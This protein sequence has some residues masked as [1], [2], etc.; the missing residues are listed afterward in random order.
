MRIKYFNRYELKYIIQ[1]SQ[2]DEMATALRDYMTF[3]PHSDDGKAYV[4]TSLY[5]DTADYRAYWNKIEGHRYRRKVRIRVYDAT[6]VTPETDCFVEIKARHN[7]VLQKKRVVLPYQDALALCQQAQAVEAEA[8][9]EATIQEVRYLSYALDLRPTAVVSYNRLAFNGSE[10]DVGLRVTFDTNLQ[11]RT[12][13][14]SLLTSS[15]AESQY[16]VPPNYCIMEIKVNNRVPYWLTEF[17]GKYRCTLQRISKYCAALEN[18]KALL[19]T[20]RVVAR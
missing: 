16:F 13:A 7:K 6:E 5:F 19:N 14:L 8:E 20:Q 17:I 2:A 11:G 15:G 18:S 3:D 12:H 9:D 1:R 4:V 10:Y